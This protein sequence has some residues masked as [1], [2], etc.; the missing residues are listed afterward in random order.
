MPLYTN[1]LSPKYHCGLIRSHRYIH[2]SMKADC[3]N[4][5]TQQATGR[6][7]LTS[8]VSC[9]LILT[10]QWHQWQMVDCYCTTYMYIHVHVYTCP[11]IPLFHT[12]STHLHKGLS[13]SLCGARRCNDPKQGDG[14][15]QNKVS[16]RHYK[17]TNLAAHVSVL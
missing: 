13:S 5:H 4:T 15:T 2:V 10:D 6:L 1:V 14:M 12:I 7:E 17:I 3:T 11:E 8:P 9:I 16:G